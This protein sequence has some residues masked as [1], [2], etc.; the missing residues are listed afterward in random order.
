MLNPHITLISWRGKDRA[1]KSFKDYTSC[2]QSPW[3]QALFVLPSSYSTGFLGT[4]PHGY[5]SVL[6]AMEDAKQETDSCLHYTHFMSHEADRLEVNA[7]ETKYYG[8]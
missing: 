8:N 7:L 3:L 1:L 5:P 2:F 6:S 4:D